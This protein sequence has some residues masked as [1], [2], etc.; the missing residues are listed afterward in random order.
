MAPPTDASAV[1]SGQPCA[2]G[3]VIKSGSPNIVEA[4]G[5]TDLD[6]VLIDRQHAAPGLETIENML[7]A[8]DL[9]DL[10]AIVRLPQE[11]L[12]LVSNVLDAGA[13]G[14]MLP[15]TET[16]DQVD[17]LAEHVRYDAGRSFSPNTRAGRFGHGGLDFDTIDN[18]LAVIPQIESRTGLDNVDAIAAHDAV[19]TLAIG[20]QDLSLS[21]GLDRESEAFNDALEELFAAECGA[22]TFVSGPDDL[23]DFRG[24]AP[25]VACGSDIGLV[26]DV[27]S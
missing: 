4:L 6:F 11:D 2:I 22:G 17:R 15:Q 16:I 3:T 27:F 19:T 18:A 13:G 25:F 10:P 8:A 20:P 14:V 26:T 21:L 5:Y 9:N 24:R 12:D 7:R 23:A 1:L